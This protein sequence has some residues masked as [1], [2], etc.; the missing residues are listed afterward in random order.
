MKPYSTE[1]QRLEEQKI[2]NEKRFTDYQY[3]WYR[4]FHQLPVKNTICT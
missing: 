3:K 4:R 1:K 2:I